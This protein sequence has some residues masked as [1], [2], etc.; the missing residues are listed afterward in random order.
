MRPAEKPRILVFLHDRVRRLPVA[1]FHQFDRAAKF[2]ALPEGLLQQIKVC[3]NV[4]QLQFPVKIGDKFQI[5]EPG[6][7]EQRRSKARE[8]V[9]EHR[10]L[11]ASRPRSAT[12]SDDNDQGGGK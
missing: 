3:N 9:Q 7:F 8:K 1:L 5:W 10:K 12:S 11:F 2:V 6:A 4:V